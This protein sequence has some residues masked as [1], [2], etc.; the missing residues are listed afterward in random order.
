MGNWHLGR[1]KCLFDFLPLAAKWDI[2]KVV[3]SPCHSQMQISFYHHE[4]RSNDI[5]KRHTNNNLPWRIYSFQS[6]RHYLLCSFYFQLYNSVINCSQYNTILIIYFICSFF[7]LTFSKILWP[8]HNACGILF[9]QSGI[10]PAPPTMKAWSLNHW[11]T[12]E[13]PRVAHFY[14]DSI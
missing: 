6:I 14:R 12:E 1:L 5:L 4:V 2:A 8:H 11:T 13:F 7:F 10:K 9:P 3:F